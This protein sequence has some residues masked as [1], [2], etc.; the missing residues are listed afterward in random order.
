[1]IHFITM[2]SKEKRQ[3]KW[4]VLQ[5]ATACDL[6]SESDPEAEVTD[7]PEAVTC[8][9]CLEALGAP[10]TFVHERPEAD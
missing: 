9:E 6:T 8:D 10:R 4:I 2:S 3:G 7:V 1:M 5:W